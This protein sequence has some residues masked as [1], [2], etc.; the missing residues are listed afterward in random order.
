[1]LSFSTK[2][3]TLALLEHHVTKSEILPQICVSVDNLKNDPAS[4]E[5]V[6]NDRF[7]N[8]ELAVRSSAMTE[9]SSRE[10]KAGEYL[11]LLT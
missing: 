9:D 8:L 7:K 3:E 2:A 6:V 10:S 11:T 5:A 1:M 4:I